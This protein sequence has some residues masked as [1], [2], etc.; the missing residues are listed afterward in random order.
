M[1]K[2]IERVIE[3]LK[4]RSSNE[5]NS[6]KI[7]QLGRLPVD[8]TCKFYPGA[9]VTELRKLKELGLPADYLDFLRITNGLEL[10]DEGGSMSVICH[11]YSVQEVFKVRDFMKNSGFY[12]EEDL[13]PILQLRDIGEIYIN[14]IKYVAGENY[15]SYPFPDNN[16]FQ[17]SFAEWL[18]RFVVGEGSEFWYFLNL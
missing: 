6:F 5:Q 10:F 3:S 9:T 16:Y 15:L 18:E 13:F 1:N 11:I 7:F 14:R 2:Q 12:S 8:V 17:F 4:I